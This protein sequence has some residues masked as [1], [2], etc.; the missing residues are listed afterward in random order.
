[1]YVTYKVN[2]MF[3]IIVLLKRY[4]LRVREKAEHPLI[5]CIIARTLMT[6]SG[7]RHAGPKT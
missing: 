2:Q 5:T 4:P 6:S 7:V 3:K 1:M